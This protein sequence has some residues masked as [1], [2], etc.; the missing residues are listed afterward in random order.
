MTC[1]KAPPRCLEL[2]RL[3]ALVCAVAALVPGNVGASDSTENPCGNQTPTLQFDR[4]TVVFPVYK[5]LV[6]YDIRL[7]CRPSD[8]V[9]VDISA[10][11]P[12]QGFRFHQDLR[13]KWEWEP[14]QTGGWHGNPKTSNYQ[15]KITPDD[16]DQPHGVI[17][18][19]YYGVSM[20]AR[21]GARYTFQKEWGDDIQLVNTIT[22]GNGT[23]VAAD[24]GPTLSYTDPGDCPGYKWPKTALYFLTWEVEEGQPI[25]VRFLH[26]I[27]R[28]K[29]PPQNLFYF[30]LLY[31]Q[32]H[33]LSGDNAAT[34]QD[35]H[36]SFP[37]VGRFVIPKDSIK[38]RYD[39]A[40]TRAQ[41]F[42]LSIPT[43]CREGEQGKRKAVL[44][45]FDRNKSAAFTSNFFQSH[46]AHDQVEVTIKDA[47][48]CADGSKEGEPL[49]YPSKKISGAA[50][51][52]VTH[53]TIGLSWDTAPGATGYEVQFQPTGSGDE[54]LSA[55]TFRNSVVL[56]GLQPQTAYQIRVHPI[57]RGITGTFLASPTLQATTKLHKPR[58]G[59]ITVGERTHD[60]IALTWPA[61]KGAEKY[62]VRYWMEG[63]KSKTSKRVEVTDNAVTLENLKANRRY[64]FKVGYFINGELVSGKVSEPA[65]AKTRKAP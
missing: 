57:V 29:V 58:L 45:L 49:F 21:C 62:Q 15:F 56:H 24:A 14:R 44:Q 16:W 19:N 23:P 30:Y 55:L 13:P 63:K 36:E 28:S 51:T 17:L 41:S 38:T 42:T 18:D 8:E 64:V 4:D 1:P 46:R 43:V 50:V 65:K 31:F 3:I 33:G 32:G 11:N 54:W 5:G 61:I 40:E 48:V 37:V 2:S 26:A 59:N 12:G 7:S 35:F 47:A 39:D 20:L 52:K 9:T 34:M 10:P 25:Q 22:V 53:N 27:P 60:S 6:T